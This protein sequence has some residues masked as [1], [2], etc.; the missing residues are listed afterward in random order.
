MND[1]LKTKL[2]DL[3]FN[4]EQIAK[5][6]AQGVTN[7]AEMGMLSEK[8]VREITGC[9]VISAKNTVAAFVSAPAQEPASAAATIQNL[10]PAIPDDVSFLEMLK[11]GGVLKIDRTDVIAAI[12]SAV[13]SKVGLFELPDKLSEKME[14]FAESQDEP[15]GEAFFKIQKQLT[16]RRYGD[17]L[18]A[19][20]ANGTFVSE[21]RKRELLSRLNQDLW[22]ALNGFQQQLSAWVT[23]WMQ[24]TSNPGMLMMAMAMSHQGSSSVLPPGILQPPETVV[25][26]DGAEGVIN[27]VNHVFAGTGRIVARAMAFDATSIKTV[28]D[29]P[30]LP[31]MVGA[32]NRDQMLK[33]VGSAVSADFVRLEQN[34]ARFAL[35]IMELPKIAAGNEELAYFSA[36][37]TL[38][39]QIPWD[40]LG[41]SGSV[42]VPYMSTEPHA[43]IHGDK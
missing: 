38:G 11:V 14:D 12:R 37:Y 27:K 19:L 34:I 22:P 16:Q 1:E 26:R 4:D 15:V 33:M 43:R 5:L 23:A 39:S 42:S 21:K 40:K 20:G 13:A 7:Q 24:G 6:E 41:T 31:S 8:E 29:D 30:N 3:K 35:A 25:L 32:A 10:L 28:L 18:A 9:N 2:K 17:V 36:M